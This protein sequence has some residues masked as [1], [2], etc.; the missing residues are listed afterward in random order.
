MQSIG[1]ALLESLVPVERPGDFAVGGLKEAPLPAIEVDGVGRIAF[2]L[3]PIQA[4]QLIAMAEPAPY[5]RGPETLVDRDVRRT[6]QIAPDRMMFRGRHWEATLDAIADE[7][8]LGLGVIG[9]VAAD[10]YKLLIYD[11]GS[12]F[13]DHRD[14]EKA[15]GM[16]ATLVVV[17]PSA[18]E[19][20]ELV[21]RHLDR[22]IILD[23]RPLDPSEIGF[24]AFYADCV[25][26]IRP[27]V[28]GCRAALIYNLRFLGGKH[29]PSPPDYHSEQ[30]RV[31]ALLRSWPDSEDEPDK[32]ILPLEHA[33]TQAE[34]S[35]DALKGRDAAIASLLVGAAADAACDLHLAL[36]SIEESGSAYYNGYGRNRRWGRQ[37]DDDDEYEIGEICVSELTL[38]QWRSP[39][40]EVGYGPLAFD[41][42]ELCLADAIEDLTPDE[43]HF[44]EA[45][46]N[47]GASFERTY[48]RAGLVLWPR[49]RRLAVLNQAGLDITL[50][51]LEDLVRRREAD[52][53]D[54]ASHLL[55]EAGALSDLMLA[56]WPGRSWRPDDESD[57]RASRMLDL[58]VRLGSSTRIETFLTDV[59]A[60][61]NYRASDNP[62]ILR[63]L[64]LLPHEPALALLTG[65]VAC[66]TS[67]HVGGCID[68]VQ[69]CAAEADFAADLPDLGATLLDAL[70]GDPAKRPDTDPWHRAEKVSPRIVADL[71]LLSSRID[72]GLADRVVDHMLAWPSTYEPDDILVPA[73]R[74][75]IGECADWPAVVRLRTI[76]LDHLR[77]RIALPLEAPKDWTRSNPIRCTCAE[78]AELVGFLSAPDREIWR[79]KAIQE[80][81][82]HVE[83][84]I[85]NHPCDVDLAT[86]KRGS[87]HVLVVSKN[88]ASHDRRVEQRRQDLAQVAALGG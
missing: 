85:R 73:A 2:P 42:E 5:G 49:S 80:R 66:N 11:P 57:T 28:S 48:R 8:A 54:P 51:H 12:F 16:F 1:A 33:Y 67:S 58:Q 7:A 44:Q 34:L 41:E 24:A 86:E 77:A 6:W 38:S 27:I 9:P 3:L 88:Q 74:S 53:D 19:G 70:P 20:G 76:C 15:P 82:S 59:T 78:C 62:A 55:E 81:R 14:T 83:S 32:L 75:L 36:V 30:D 25:H 29:A 22:E 26:E 37:D 84:S 47:E 31:A 69:R 64:K 50:P 13:V 60:Q 4:E 21:V 17:L 40:G 35:F 45:T 63:S 39:D 61:G 46:G 52:G 56:S 79:L 72:P 65:I 18:H 23:P 10:F 71:V 43:I 87:P 68:L